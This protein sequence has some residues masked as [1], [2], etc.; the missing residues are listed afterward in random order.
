[1]RQPAYSRIS[2][3]VGDAIRDGAIPQG[4]I[5]LEGPI[6]ALFRSSRSPVK[7]ALRA[8]Q[9]EGLVRRFAGRG[10]VV[11][12]AEPT[13][14]AITA[15]TLG[16][17]SDEL[18]ERPDPLQSI[19]YAVEREIILHS[20]RGTLR[21]NE[22]ALAR[23]HGISRAGARAI[24]LRARET[25]LVLKGEN[26]QWRIRALDGTR[27]AQLYDLR[28]LLE[29]AALQLAAERLSEET[30]DEMSARLRTALARFPE[31]GVDAL[32]RMEADLHVT[33]VG[34]ATNVEIVGALERAHPTHIAGK[35]LQ[36]VLAVEPMV[37]PFMGEHLAV[38]DALLDRRVGDAC[39]ALVAHLERS[40]RKVLRRLNDYL[41]LD[42]PAPV[43]YIR[44]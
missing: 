23:Y 35:H 9:D 2:A 6:A 44:P 16:L 14:F 12:P 7:Q 1:M 4:A 31:I 36:I 38:F 13:R 39:D 3:I 29:P 18:A 41:E 22:L 26:A 11:G 28:L 17:P 21:I 15:E 34:H 8:L 19:Y 30:L 40:K 24:L 37:D 20:L 32:D 10:L 43:D 27:C 5:L 42:P 33:V 25:G